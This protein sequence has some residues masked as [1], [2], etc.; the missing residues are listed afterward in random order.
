MTSVFRYSGRVVIEFYDVDRDTY[1]GSVTTPN[2]TRHEAALL[3]PDEKADRSPRAFDMAAVVFLGIAQE[4]D[5]PDGSPAIFLDIPYFA[6]RDDNGEYLIAR[7][8]IA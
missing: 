7:N 8:P 4:W 3:V 1:I 2:G 6:E 5:N